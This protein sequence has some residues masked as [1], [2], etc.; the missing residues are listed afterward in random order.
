MIIH[1]VRHGEVENP[2]HIV[3]ADLPGFGLSARGAIQVGE[4]ADYLAGKRIGA[5]W[6]S[7][8]LRAKQTAERIAAPHAVEICVSNALTEWGLSQRWRGVRWEELANRFPGELAA[9]FDHPWDLPFSSESLHAVVERMTT[10]VQDLRR[11]YAGELVVVSHQDPLQA[12]RLALTDGDLRAFW[13][14][15]P[16]HAE[17]VTLAADGGWAEVGRWKPPSSSTRFPPAP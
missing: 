2:D 15:K 12:A 14:G 4:T 13:E 8:L 17:V 16:D 9:Y 7:P 11:T 1:F 3:Y 6:T 10:L 5:V